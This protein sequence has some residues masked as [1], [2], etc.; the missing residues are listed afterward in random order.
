M[1]RQRLAPGDADV[2]TRLHAAALASSDGGRPA[3]AVRELR[4]GLR[5]VTGQPALTELRS[6]ILLSL[7]WAESERGRVDRGF[8]LLDEA[9]TDAPQEI[10]PILLAQRALLLKRAGHNTVALEHY[11]SAIALMTEGTY[12]QDLVRALNNRSL[13]HQEAGRLRL[14]RADLT[15]ALHIA[16]RQGLELQ[17]AVIGTNLGCLDVT[18]GDLPAAL[19]AFATARATYQTLAPGRL[20]NLAVER[21]RALLAAGLFSQA[22]R[23]LAEAISQ[24]HGQQLDHTYADALQVRAEVALL[25]GDPQLSIRWARQAR[26]AFLLRRNARRAA[27]AELIV[28]RAGLDPTDPRS[29]GRPTT[30]GRALALAARLTRLGLSEDARIAAIVAVRSMI[31]SGATARATRTLREIGRPRPIDRLDTRLL[32]WLARAELASAS[33]KPAQTRSA[34]LA[35][36]AALHRHRTQFGSL[37]LQTGAAARGQEL[38]RAG[39]AAAVARGPAA[40]VYRW[41]E[42][43]RAQALL[44][45]PVRPPTDA[46]A[47]ALLDELRQIRHA[48][49]DAELAGRPADDLRR[50]IDELQRAIRERSWSTPGRTATPTP[51]VAPLGRVAAEL[52]GAA[53][54][55]YLVTEGV[56]RALVLTGRSAQLVPLAGYE[57]AAEAVLRLRADLDAQ[58]TTVLPGQ[59]ARAVRAA[60]RR[61]AERLADIL[62]TPLLPRIGDR[63]LV[64]VPTG[65]LMTTPWAVLPGCGGRPVTVAPSATAWL[66]ARQRLRS[67]TK[68]DV[69]VAARSIVLA[70]GPGTNRGAAEVQAIGRVYPTATILTGADATPAATLG[71]LDGSDLAHLAAH[72]SH[73]AENALFS[74]LELSGGPLLGYDVLRL[75]VAPS[76]VVLSSCDLGLADVRPG[77]ET[78]GMSTALLA[79]GTATVV[80]SVGRVSDEVAM[81]V[82]VGFHEAVAAGR[83]PAAALAGAVPPGSAA[84]FICFGTG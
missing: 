50:R 71:A 30:T 64:V 27:L 52:G 73:Q 48:F 82:M 42:R 2:A 8:Q 1:T 46:P 35:G 59:L 19:H 79:A 70:A 72:G 16:D 53:L 4:A 29:E 15:R 75:R 12:P 13:V 58:V 54:V 6:R 62:L 33:G 5:L 78:F 84:A 22:D 14:A 67:S 49:R 68:A 61:D 77:D 56:L 11:D 39:L 83:A 47:A 37:D 44:L 10:R 31:A 74:T 57:E 38:A 69:G 76:M 66:A 36:M 17:A 34:L 43:A 80:A 24:A 26:A 18:A 55:V 23:E 7:A 60:T 21:A 41:C 32:W 51:Y 63:D 28:L 3:R 81:T 25:A 9:E 45:A 20:A 40:A 65:P